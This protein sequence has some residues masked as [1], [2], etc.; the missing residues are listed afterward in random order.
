MRAEA[1]ERSQSTQ[2]NFTPEDVLNCEIYRGS[3]RADC[4]QTD[5]TKTMDQK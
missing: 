3:S 1:Q 2:I 5:A 4:Q